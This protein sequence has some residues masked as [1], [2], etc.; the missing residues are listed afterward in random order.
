MTDNQHS[1][2]AP[3]WNI[4]LG[5]LAYQVI[6]AVEAVS[7]GVEQIAKFPDV[8]EPMRKPLALLE[9]LARDAVATAVEMQDELFKT[10]GLGGMS[11]PANDENGQPDA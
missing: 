7:A 11:E 2:Q 6:I 4:E 9:D 1:S 3:A 5:S 10:F 8:P